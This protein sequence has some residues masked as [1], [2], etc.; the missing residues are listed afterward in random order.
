[1]DRWMDRWMD[2][3]ETEQPAHS[4]AELPKRTPTCAEMPETSSSLSTAAT[5]C[6]HN[7]HDVTLFKVVADP[8]LKIRIAFILDELKAHYRCRYTLISFSDDEYSHI[9]CV[10]SDDSNCRELFPPKLAHFRGT[11]FCQQT[12]HRPIPVII[13]SLRESEIFREH[14][15][16]VGR[17]EITSYVG[18]PMI[19]DDEYVGALCMFW[20]SGTCVDDIRAYVKAEAAS[21]MISSLLRPHRLA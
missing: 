19:I 10:Q 3:C 14:P 18:I 12:L 15:F 1:M 11:S 4:W 6:I 17:P 16:V 13:P 8:P 9:P 21:Q 2:G 20:T 7:T 5:T